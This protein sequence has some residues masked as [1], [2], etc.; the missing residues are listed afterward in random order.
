MARLNWNCLNYQRKNLDLK[1]SKVHS[2]TWLHDSKFS[3]FS[4]IDTGKSVSKNASAVG[5]R[6][7]DPGLFIPL[8]M[9]AFECSLPTLSRLC[10]LFWPM[11]YSKHA[12]SRDL[13]NAYAPGLPSLA[14]RGNHHHMNKPR[15]AYWRCRVQS[16]PP[17][18]PTA[19]M[20]HR[21]CERA[22]PR[23]MVSWPHHWLTVPTQ[24]TLEEASR[25]SAQL[26]PS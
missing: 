12:T 13:K 21:T 10:D 16:S 25:R 18:Y 22:H 9:L 26:N 23:P 8:C 4:L 1:T 17:P 2:V 6:S 5:C 20:K 3:Y 15:L 11:G 19:S 7:N 14:T 24:V